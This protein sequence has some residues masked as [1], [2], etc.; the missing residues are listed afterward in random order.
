MVFRCKKAANFRGMIGENKWLALPDGRP[1]EGLARFSGRPQ[2]VHFYD[3]FHLTWY[4][5]C[6][7]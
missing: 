7:R 4:S 1:L 3:V 5:H 6:L 2:K